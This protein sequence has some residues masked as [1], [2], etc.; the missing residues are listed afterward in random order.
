MSAF[1]IEVKV[2]FLSTMCATR[3]EEILASL[4]CPICIEYMAAS[5]YVCSNGHSICGS[6]KE[7]VT[8]C[9]MCSVIL[10]STKNF[11]L[12]SLARALYQTSS[13]LDACPFA[14]NG[15]KA[16]LALNMLDEH[17]QRCIFRNF[18]CIFDV[19]DRQCDFMGKRSDLKEH[20]R[21]VHSNYLVENGKRMF[22]IK[23]P[24]DYVTCFVFYEKD[25]FYFHI[26][27]RGELLYAW[28]QHIGYPTRALDYV[29]RVQ[30]FSE[31]R[32]SRECQV[33]E[34]C[35]N[36]FETFSAV[37]EAKRCIVI[38]VEHIKTYPEK[39]YFT[40]HISKV[41]LKSGLT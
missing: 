5:I 20:L 30:V 15:C 7:K 19:G 14:A 38:S 11:A 9:P 28:L 29:Y 10:G 25:L 32:S 8:N 18:R 35:V 23:F 33:T 13:A 24:F 6:C 22:P 3:N 4:E 27:Q 41:P 17:K 31:P 39:V 37:V 2:S 21:T 34:R 12:E 40:L 16:N 26:E 1:V 36:N